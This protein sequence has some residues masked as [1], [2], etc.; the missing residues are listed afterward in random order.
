[1]NVVGH[2]HKGMQIKMTKMVRAILDY[3]HYC[4]CDFFALQPDGA[5]SSFVKIAIQPDECLTAG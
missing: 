1:M 3:I 4:T 2:D 5:A